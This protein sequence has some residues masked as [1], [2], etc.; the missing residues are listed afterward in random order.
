M[1]FHSLK[2]KENVQREI[3]DQ[4]REGSSLLIKIKMA[5]TTID[6]TSSPKTQRSKKATVAIDP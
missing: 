1:T 2:E 3:V 6:N 4:C 5:I